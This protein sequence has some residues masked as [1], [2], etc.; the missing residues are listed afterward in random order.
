M[1]KCAIEPLLEKWIEKA[2]SLKLKPITAFVKTIYEHYD[3]I[4]KSM[5]T[6]ITNAVS[7]GLNRVMQLARSR[8]RGYRNQENYCT[9]IYYLGNA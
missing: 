8:A 3:G 5:I 4:I 1:Q 7:E 6:G 9:M 2:L